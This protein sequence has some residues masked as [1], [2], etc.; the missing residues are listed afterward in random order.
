MDFYVPDGHSLLDRLN[1]ESLEVPARRCL[2]ASLEGT[3]SDTLKTSL[4]YPL[5][6]SVAMS[7]WMPVWMIVCGAAEGSPQ[8]G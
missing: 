2:K 3:V 1:E 4:E 5:R 8:R 6:D 7:V